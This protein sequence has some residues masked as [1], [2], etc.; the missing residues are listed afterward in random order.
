MSTP[1]LFCLAEQGHGGSR[2]LSAHGKGAQKS[3]VAERHSVQASLRDRTKDRT[4]PLAGALV[5]PAFYSPIPR[6][7][8][9]PSSVSSHWMDLNALGWTPFFAEAF[10]LCTQPGW[11]AAR[12]AVEHRGGYRLY[13]ARGELDAEVSGRFRYEAAVPGD[14]PA[15][16]DWVVI[17]THCE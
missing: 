15:I 9:T 6:L 3:G 13:S 10:A 17:E 2:G 16:G 11:E 7:V 12:V 5:S 14:F 4:C 8:P 1:V